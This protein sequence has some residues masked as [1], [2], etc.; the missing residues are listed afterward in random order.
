MTF[1]NN[2]VP[3]HWIAKPDRTAAQE[4]RDRAVQAATINKLKEIGR[5]TGGEKELAIA[6]LQRLFGKVGEKVSV[7]FYKFINYNDQST[8]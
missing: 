4:T 2:P 8:T 5:M 3:A 7:D 6:T 1:R